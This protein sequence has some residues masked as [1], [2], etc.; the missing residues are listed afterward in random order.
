MP[1]ESFIENNVA[2]ERKWFRFS[3]AIWIVLLLLLGASASG[4]SGGGG[5]LARRTSSASNLRVGWERVVR[6]HSV[7]HWRFDVGAPDGEARVDLRGGLVS[8]STLRDITPPPKA[9]VAGPDGL[10]LIYDAE[11]GSFATVRISQALH[12]PGLLRSRVQSGQSSFALE[13]I[14]LP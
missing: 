6:A 10:T 12:S 4:L 3:R 7:A 8:K 5:P 9:V 1:G 2:F 14:V 13:Q 11:P